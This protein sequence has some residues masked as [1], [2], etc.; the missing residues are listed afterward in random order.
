[1]AYDPVKD[2][3]IFTKSWENEDEDVRITVSIYSYNDGDGK[4]QIS[5]EKA[6]ADGEYMFAKLGRMTQEEIENVLPLIQEAMK[7][8]PKGEKNDEKQSKKSKAGK[9]E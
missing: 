6:N 7:K 1:M 5:R 2:K 9:E 8:F 4:L 3:Q